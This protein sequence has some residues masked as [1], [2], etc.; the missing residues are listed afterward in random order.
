MA[1][2]TKFNLK[3]LNKLDS[4]LY[5]KYTRQLSIENFICNR[6]KS[7][8]MFYQNQINIKKL[9]NIKNL[10]NKNTEL[11]FKNLK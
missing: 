6:K 5:I 7:A 9:I 4:L 8:K 2:T 3:Q 11:V 1:Q 10:S